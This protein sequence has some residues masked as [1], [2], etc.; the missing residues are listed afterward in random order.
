MTEAGANTTL[1]FVP[2]RFAA[3]AVYEAVDAGIGTVIRITED[4]PAHEMLRVTP[5]SAAGA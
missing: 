1:I 4:I 3:D 5:T 2:A